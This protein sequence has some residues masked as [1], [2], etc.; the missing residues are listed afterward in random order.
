MFLQVG[1]LSKALVA[2]L[3]FER[4]F[5]TVHSQVDLEEATGVSSALT[6]KVSAQRLGCL[7][8]KCLK[9]SVKTKS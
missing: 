8:C 1:E 5:S 4:P 2:G 6:P 9:K 7:W 3:A